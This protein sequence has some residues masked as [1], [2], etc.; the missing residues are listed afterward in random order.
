MKTNPNYMSEYRL[1]NSTL[2]EKTFVKVDQ[3]VRVAMEFKDLIN[4]T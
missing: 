4:R 1:N 3:N 2:F